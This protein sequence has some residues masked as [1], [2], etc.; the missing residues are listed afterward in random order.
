MR[1]PFAPSPFITSRPNRA[2]RLVCSFVRLLGARQSVFWPSH[3]V[4]KI[5]AHPRHFTARQTLSHLLRLYF[6]TEGAV[7]GTPSFSFCWRKGPLC[8][9]NS[10]SHPHRNRPTGARGFQD[11]TGTT[12]SP[13]DQLVD[14]HNPR[15]SESPCQ[16]DDHQ[17]PTHPGVSG[18]PNQLDSKAM[19]LTSRFRNVS[20]PTT[21]WVSSYERSSKSLHM[22]M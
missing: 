17:R 13:A 21:I 22:K 19:R 18:R 20:K 15:A 1:Y 3:F 12:F 5:H 16:R 6:L 2:I 11:D 8:S 4:P 14:R 10:H 9:N 7:E